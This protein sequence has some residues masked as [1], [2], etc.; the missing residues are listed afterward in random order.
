MVA[1]IAGYGWVQKNMTFSQALELSAIADT[2]DPPFKA[3]K[4]KGNYDLDWEQTG[5][6]ELNDSDIYLVES[7]AL[8]FKMGD[9]WRAKVGIMTNNGA[10][11]QG[12]PYVLQGYFTK[13]VKRTF[14]ETDS[15]VVQEVGL[16]SESS[17]AIGMGFEDT[18]LDTML[19][20]ESAM[21]VSMTGGDY[22]SMDLDEKFDGIYRFRL[23][24]DG[25]NRNVAD[26]DKL[27]DNTYVAFL[28]LEHYEELGVG[29]DEEVENSQSVLDPFN[30]NDIVFT[31]DPNNDPDN[32]P[33]VCEEGFTL[34]DGI[35]VPDEPEEPTADLLDY[36]FFVGI[37]ALLGIA[38]G[39]IKVNR[40]A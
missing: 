13:N 21:A 25:E 24:I 37:I 19:N 36:A 9:N 12:A 27:D 31:E 30:P 5:M 8:Y 3:L 40:G 33:I 23:N 28:E 1:P 14:R 26:P 17:I 2:Q 10:S 20:P 16:L 22:I 18:L 29:S 6:L 4:L 38:L 39:L 7:A 11:Y 34:I 35:C 32:P 15:I